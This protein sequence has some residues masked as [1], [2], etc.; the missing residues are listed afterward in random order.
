MSDLF[1]IGEMVRLKGWPTLEM[2]VKGHCYGL[3]ICTWLDGEG[4]RQ[5][6]CFSESGLERIPAVQGGAVGVASHESPQNLQ[7]VRRA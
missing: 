5:T 2:H 3:T 7:P 4:F 6:G 1:R